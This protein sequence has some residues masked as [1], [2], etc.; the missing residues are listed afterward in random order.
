MSGRPRQLR[1]VGRPAALGRRL[2][3]GGSRRLPARTGGAAALPGSP[4]LLT[5][6]YG[7][8]APVRV[9]RAR[10]VVAGDA[11]CAPLRVPRA[12][13]RGRLRPGRGGAA[14]S[15]VPLA[16]AV[17]GR[18]ARRGRRALSREPPL[19]FR[20]R[21][22]KQAPLR[23]ADCAALRVSVVRARGLPVLVPV[24]RAAVHA[25]PARRCVAAPP[26]AAAARALPAAL[27]DFAIRGHG[28]LVPV[29]VRRGAAP[30]RR[31]RPC[32]AARPSAA[33]AS[34]SP[35]AHRD[36]L[37]RGCGLLALVPVRRAA[38]PA[39]RAR[40][41]VAPPP[42]PALVRASPTLPRELRVPAR[43][44]PVRRVV[45]G[46][47]GRAPLR[48]RPTGA[49]G[50]LRLARGRG[51]GSGLP[52]A[53]APGRG[54]ASHVARAPRRER[55]LLLRERR[56]W[57]VA[58]GD[59]RRAPLRGPAARP[60]DRRAP[61]PG[62]PTRGDVA[63]AAVFLALAAG[64]GY[65]A[66]RRVFRPAVRG[67]PRRRAAVDSAP[68]VQ[69]LARQTPPRGLRPVV[70]ERRARR[71]VPLACSPGRQAQRRALPT[72]DARPRARSAPAPAH[73]RLPRHHACGL[74]A[75]ARSRPSRSLPDATR[76]RCRLYGA[77]PRDA[78]PTRDPRSHAL[79][80]CAPG[81][82]KP[83][84]WQ[85]LADRFGAP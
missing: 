66:R 12:G 2:R 38:A 79:V 46:G 27:R 5:G 13:A 35:A 73:V 69:S 42:S 41:C 65:R 40:P 49:R 55:Q 57:R 63:R 77:A 80:N 8:R 20:E 3:R 37:I 51:D 6:R 53:G 85:H 7:S 10:R 18:A 43:G 45:A 76:H 1:L 82:P 16:A 70:R 33:P 39:P 71:A 9:S 83:L 78:R 47:A 28:L 84:Q 52:L 23:A 64:R 22:V 50:R 54:A 30:G 32:V 29:P 44:S 67:A 72:A 58:V 61:A 19:R 21:R 34:A 17:V 74:T 48:A 56:A 11:A 59:A 62:R 4:P 31:A 60:R 14:A 24:R 26:S 75:P 15:P 36:F 81:P 68:C 25:L